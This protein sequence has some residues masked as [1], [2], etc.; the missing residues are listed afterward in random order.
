M[1]QIAFWQTK[2]FFSGT[3]RDTIYFY[4]VIRSFYITDT[5]FQ[6]VSISGGGQHAIIVMDKK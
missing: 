6:I 4:I 5:S 3:L 2:C 1:P